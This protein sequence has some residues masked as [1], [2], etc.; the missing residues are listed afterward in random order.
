[1]SRKLD[2]LNALVNSGDTAA[3]FAF[4]LEF[5]ADE[6]DRVDSNDDE[7][8][9]DVKE[10]SKKFDDFIKIDWAKFNNEHNRFQGEIKGRATMLASVISGAGLILANLHHIIRFFVGG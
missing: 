8:S 5:V 2:A 1:M 9:A 4:V 10:L 6:I 3:V 7:I